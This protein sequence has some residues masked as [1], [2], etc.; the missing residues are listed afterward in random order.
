VALLGLKLV[1]AI[2][3]FQGA[4]RYRRADGARRVAGLRWVGGLG[5]LIVFLAAVLKWIYERALLT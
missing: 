3:M 1:L 5:L 2:A 4:F